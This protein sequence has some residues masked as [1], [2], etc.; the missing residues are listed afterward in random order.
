[1]RLGTWIRRHRFV[2]GIIVVT[3]VAAG[4]GAYQL[5]QSSRARQHWQQAE[6]AVA[7]RE[8]ARAQG[9]LRAF[10]ELR[11]DS[12]EAHFLLAQACRRARVEDFDGAQAHLAEARWLHLSRPGIALESDLLEFQQS[13]RRDERER[14]LHQ[15]LGDPSVDRRLV[16]EALARG[17][18]RGERLEEAVTWLDRWVASYPDDWYA[19][20]VRG[21]LFQHMDKPA[22][23]VADLER[24]LQLKPDLPDINLRLGLT[25]VQSGCDYPRALRLLEDYRRDHPDDIDTIV[26]IARCKSVLNHP[27]E[28]RELLLPI[29]IAKPDQA[30]ALQAIAIVEMDLELYPEAVKHLRQLEPL[31]ASPPVEEAFQKL[32]RLEPTADSRSIPNRLQAVYQL[33]STVYRRLGATHEAE[34]YDRKLEEHGA[35]VKELLA[36]AKEHSKNP[37]DS[38]LWYKMGTLNLRV[39]IKDTGEYWLKRVVEA[40]PNDRRAH[41]ALADLYRSRPDP[42][43]QR[44]A[45]LHEQRA[46]SNK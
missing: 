5:Q 12:A 10:L 41:R 18:I 14:R 3:A 9:E 37:N 24:V 22:P 36:A 32:L 25:H 15:L 39:G 11:G 8:F 4:V 26:G 2:T 23:A 13:G 7:A 35:A 33:L 46:G 29:A 28:A 19:Y 20:F 45:D 44:K 1:M 21:T 30:D 16:L 31:A 27:E 42:E 38:D 40:N 6:E 17:C 43:S 34:A